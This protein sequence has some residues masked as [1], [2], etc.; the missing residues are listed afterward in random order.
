MHVLSQFQ[1]G[2]V[3][4]TSYLRKLGFGGGGQ[5]GLVLGG[6]GVVLFVVIICVPS[7]VNQG[8]L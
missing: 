6:E 2:E 4:H 7:F 5:E 3:S 1:S 8:C